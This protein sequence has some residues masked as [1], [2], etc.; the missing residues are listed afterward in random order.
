MARTT[1]STTLVLVDDE[2]HHL[3]WLVDYF[4]SKGK[5]VLPVDNANDA[6]ELLKKEIYRAVIID[7]NIP[8]LPPMDAAA[9]KLGPVYVRYPG[10][11]VAR[12]ARNLGYR[13]RQVVIYSVHRDADVVEEARILRCTYILK[14]RPKE[15]KTELDRILNFDP[16]TDE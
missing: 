15:I 1:D 11:F 13:D 4:Y 2:M 8:L 9:E 6:V 5:K 10:L 14:G 16:T 7:L 12:Q 3:S